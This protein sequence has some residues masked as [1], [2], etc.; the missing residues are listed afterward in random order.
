M[1]KGKKG[2]KANNNVNSNQVQPEQ[3]QPTPQQSNK[4]EEMAK[5]MNALQTMDL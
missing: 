3:Q 1:A 5:I 4:N 2:G